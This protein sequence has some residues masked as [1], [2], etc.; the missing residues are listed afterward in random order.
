VFDFHQLPQSPTHYL[1]YNFSE[2]FSP[3]TRCNV[4]CVLIDARRPDLKE[5]WYAVMMCVK[6]VELRTR[7]R[8]ATWQ[9]VRSRAP[10]AANFPGGKSTARNL[11]DGSL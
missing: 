2:T 11:I 10:E 7:L 3:P 8:I 1:S 5:A 4:I 6:P 9:E